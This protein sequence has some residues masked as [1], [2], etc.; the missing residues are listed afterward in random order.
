MSEFS[1]KVVVVTGAGSGIGRSSA[2][3]F[4]R[5]GAKVHVTDIDGDAAER[6]AH[7]IGGSATAHTVDS[8][9]PQAPG[10]PA[11]RVYTEAGAADVPQNTAGI[12]HAADIEETPVED[13]QR[14]IGV[15]PLGG[16]SGV[17]AF[18]PRMLKQG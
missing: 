1:G 3:L 11:A 4:G 7:E 9:D 8:T 13:W 5:L 2:L 18:V 16:A 10:E 15:T 12:G 14:V 17:Q 6:T